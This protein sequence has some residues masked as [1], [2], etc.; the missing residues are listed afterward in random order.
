MSPESNT[1]SSPLQTRPPGT[2]PLSP[3]PPTNHHLASRPS[4]LATRYALRKGLGAWEL[5]FEGRRAILKDEIGVPYVAWLLLNQPTEP[6]PALLLALR[7]EPPDR[8]CPGITEVEHPA[9]G[10]IVLVE[11]DAILQER[12]LALDDG[13][14]LRGLWHEQR[15]LEAILEERNVSQVIKAEVQHDLEALQQFIRKQGWRTKIALSPATRK[16]GRAIRRFHQRLATALDATGAPSPVL[17]AFAAHLQDCLLVPS[18]RTG[19]RGGDRH[20]MPGGSFI[21]LPPPGVVWTQ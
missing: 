12:S 21:Y 16:V 18:G 19:L 15:K 11:R 5:I 3:P 6:V 9:T 4:P 13:D 20:K 10:E 7:V 14:C 8:T 1:P 2:Q 17:R